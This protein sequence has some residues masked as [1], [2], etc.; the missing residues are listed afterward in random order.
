MMVG[1]RLVVI[2]SLF[3]LVIPSTDGASCAFP[4]DLTGDWWSS[5]KGE[6]TFTTTTL[7]NYNP[8]RKP[9][10]CSGVTS[11]WT[12]LAS[13]GNKYFI[14][15]DPFEV[16]GT[17]TT[18][19]VYAC[20]YMYRLSSTKYLAYQGPKAE[21]QQPYN[22]YVIPSRSLTYA[23]SDLCDLDENALPASRHNLFIR[24]DS[25]LSAETTCPAE[26]LGNYMS[27]N[28]GQCNVTVD[29]CTD[30]KRIAVDNMGCD[31]DN[32]TSDN[33][34]FTGNGTLSCVYSLQER[35]TTY[36]TLYSIED[37]HNDS[38]T[39]TFTCISITL[40][41]STVLIRQAPNECYKLDET[42]REYQLEPNCKSIGCDFSENLLGSWTSNRKGDLVISQ[43]SIAGFPPFGPDCLTAE[44]TTQ[45]TAYECYLAKGSRYL[46][47]SARTTLLDKSVRIYLCLDFTSVTKTKI[48]YYQAHA[49]KDPVL[50]DYL[51]TRNAALSVESIDDICT[52]DSPYDAALYS[53]LLNTA[54]PTA[55]IQDCPSEFEAIYNTTDTS[56]DYTL[57][58]CEH[59]TRIKLSATSCQRRPFYSVQ[60]DVSCIYTTNVGSTTYLTL[61]N[62]DVNVD[63]N[64]TYKFTCIA[65]TGSDKLLTFTQSPRGCYEGQAPDDAN[66][67][68][69]V[70]THLGMSRPRGVQLDHRCRCYCRSYRSYYYLPSHLV[71]LL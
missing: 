57:T 31:D 12:C 48:V 61:I 54:D 4:A 46:V 30:R 69:F 47:R 5:K 33:M 23:L 1:C 16:P 3:M 53:I 63:G 52:V 7:S 20:L 18:A 43:S 71:L 29:V 39:I 41:D 40:N 62:N 6:V 50:L 27:D 67:T 56:C 17:G 66:T 13:S 24:N 32:D 37:R 42:V 8:C 28:N 15:S 51:T 70:Y 45:P 21:R 38:L 9:E 58:T 26:L 34:F 65:F 68:T 10:D 55:G 2:L 25:T 22:D 64:D 36:V 60:G 11:T 19:Y 49:A 14:R 59:K 44:C 35:A